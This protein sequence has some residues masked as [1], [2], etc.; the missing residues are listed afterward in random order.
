[1]KQTNK[2]KLKKDVE[3][4]LDK[5]GTVTNC[6]ENNFTTTQAERE[7]AE[8]ENDKR[9]KGKRLYGWWRY[10]SLFR[11]VREVTDGKDYP[12]LYKDYEDE[13]KEEDDDE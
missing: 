13:D 10:R 5:G 2:D 9:L 3:T 7:I 4:Y 8:K 6:E 11:S 1:M 12:T